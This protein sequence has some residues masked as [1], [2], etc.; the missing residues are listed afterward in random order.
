MTTAPPDPGLRQPPNPS[1]P[2]PPTNRGLL[3]GILGVAIAALVTSLLTLGVVTL[4]LFTAFIGR[5]DSGWTG[6][7]PGIDDGE[8]Y[9]VDEYQ[10][11]SQTRQAC[12]TW[13]ESGE[14]LELFAGRAESAAALADIADNLDAVAATLTAD[15]LASADV[16]SWN[17]DLL[18]YAAVLRETADEVASGGEYGLAISDNY[19]V[20]DRLYSGSPWIC[21]IPARLDS[22][23]PIY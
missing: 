12:R 19:A 11:S 7:E 3:L 22:I 20:I 5:F 9:Y 8:Y 1:Q 16:T 6:Y 14:N 21:S 15:E 10:L 2:V 23:S 13:V 17:D 4:F 18:A